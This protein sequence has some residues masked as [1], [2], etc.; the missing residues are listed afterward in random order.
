MWRVLFYIP[1]FVVIF[2]KFGIFVGICTGEACTGILVGA[3]MPRKK[4]TKIYASRNN[5]HGTTT[6]AKMCDKCEV[7]V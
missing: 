6:T 2:A 7:R 5:K 1:D 4:N 3:A